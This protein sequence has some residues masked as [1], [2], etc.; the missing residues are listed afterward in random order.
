M[1]HVCH[2]LLLFSAHVFL[3]VRSIAQPAALPE[4]VQRLERFVGDWE[5]TGWRLTVAGNRPFQERVHCERDVLRVVC[6]TTDRQ[7]TVVNTLVLSYSDDLGAY[8]ISEIEEDGSRSTSVVQIR[9]DTWVSEFPGPEASMYRLSVT[10]EG[11][12]TNHF[13]VE[14]VTG[15]GTATVQQEGTETR[16]PVP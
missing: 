6:E 9:G 5:S 1:K 10:L 16:I 15:G 3:P 2:V 7:G 8:Q 14:R 11:R 13:K 4:H 12:D